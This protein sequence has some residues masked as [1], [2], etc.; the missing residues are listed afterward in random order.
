MLDELVASGGCWRDNSDVVAPLQANLPNRCAKTNEPAIGYYQVRLTWF[1]WWTILFLLLGPL[2]FV[3]MLFSARTVSVRVPCGATVRKRRWAH[4]R[5]SW[6]SAAACA[7]LSV[8]YGWA[9]G[10]LAGYGAA[11]AVAVFVCLIVAASDLQR[12]RIRKATRRFVW[13]AGAGAPFLNSLPIW[14]G[15]EALVEQPCV[16]RAAQSVSGAS[17]FA[18]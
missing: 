9:V 8:G 16:E 4:V 3:A 12:L 1:P 5:N 13:L 17:E 18:E 15:K 14:P 11:G 7:V 6:I 2:I 10:N